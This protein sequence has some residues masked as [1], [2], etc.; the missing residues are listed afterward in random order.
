MTGYAQAK[1]RV[2]AY[3]E[4]ETLAPEKR[5]DNQCQFAVGLRRAFVKR[6]GV[7]LSCQYTKNGSTFDLYEY[8]R[9]VVAL[10][11]SYSF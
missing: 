11:M 10:S 5:R 7:D 1:Y 4:K 3:A 8:S 2:A 9:N 6:Y